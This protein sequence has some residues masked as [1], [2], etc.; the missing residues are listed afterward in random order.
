M[1]ELDYVLIS[2]WIFI[3]LVKDMLQGSFSLSMVLHTKHI[4]KDVA[5]HVNSVMMPDLSDPSLMLSF[6]LHLAIV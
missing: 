2:A 6:Y 4:W 5:F 3:Y 1:M